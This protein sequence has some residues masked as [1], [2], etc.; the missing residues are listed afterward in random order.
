MSKRSEIT[1]NIEV[2]TV[3]YHDDDADLDRMTEVMF[4]EIRDASSV[5]TENWILKDYKI[6]SL[7]LA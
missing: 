2:K 3:A 5:P 7:E 6:E 4:E 1:L